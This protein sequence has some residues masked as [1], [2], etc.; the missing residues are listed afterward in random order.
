MPEMEI[1]HQTHF[2]LNPAPPASWVK[3]NVSLTNHV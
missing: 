2:Y 3:H 1:T